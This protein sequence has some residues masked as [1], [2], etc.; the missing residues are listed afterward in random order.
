MVLLGL[1]RGF[2]CHKAAQNDSC[3]QSERT[4]HK[5]TLRKPGRDP[6]CCTPH[7]GTSGAERTLLSR[8]Q[9]HKAPFSQIQNRTR[10]P[11]HVSSSASRD[12]VCGR[13]L[14]HARVSAGL[15]ASISQAGQDRRRNERRP[16]GRGQGGCA[17]SSTERLTATIASA[18]QND[19]VSLHAGAVTGTHT[20][21]RDRGIR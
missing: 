2:R 1:I 16:A 4:L 10:P 19:S 15:T 20:G 5:G 17:N 9:A 18:V 13:G 14:P 8:K 6:L 21:L 12:G 11:V 7:P 3:Q